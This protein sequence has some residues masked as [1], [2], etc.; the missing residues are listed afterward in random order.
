[1]VRSIGAPATQTL[2]GK[3][4]VFVSWSDGKSGTHDRRVGAGD[5]PDRRHDA[6]V[7]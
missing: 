7:V 1:M 5:G 3:T 6:A 2:N 4:Y